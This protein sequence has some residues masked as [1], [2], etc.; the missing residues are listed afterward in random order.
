MNDFKLSGNAFEPHAT[1]LYESTNVM[2][3]S[4]KGRILSAAA[5]TAI[6]VAFAKKNGIWPRL[7]RL[8]GLYLIYRGISGNCPISAM[9]E[10]GD[11]YEHIP[12]VN[13]RTSFVVNAPRKM[14]YDNWRDLGHLPRFLKH[15]KRIKVKD[16]IHSHWELKTPG[17]IPAVEWDA[18]IIEQEYGR[19]LSWRSL[20][21]SM[22][23]TAGKIN[24]A[25]TLNGTE[26]IILITYRPP[27]GHIGSAI[28]KWLNPSLRKVVERDLL[29]FK[30][31]IEEKA[32]A[33]PPVGN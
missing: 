7:M 3:V 19:E 17:K 21:G 6:Y 24:F 18:E 28:A 1:R 8:G 27:A 15:I 10:G 32:M 31:H 20:A 22:I 14:V 11:T 5:G 29:R 4:E 12:S 13:I 9:V 33:E 26:L 2:N 25:D 16:E 23:E 30:E